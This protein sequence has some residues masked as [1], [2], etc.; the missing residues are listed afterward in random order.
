MCGSLLLHSTE[1][2]VLWT[3]SSAVSDATD[4]KAE[5]QNSTQ[6]RPGPPY[7]QFPACRM[8]RMVIAPTC[9]Y[10]YKYMHIYIYIYIYICI[11]ICIGIYSYLSISFVFVPMLIFVFRFINICVCI[12]KVELVI[13]FRLVLIY[14]C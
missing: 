9:V 10:I 14:V 4:Q 2:V 5:Q 1:E 3:T 8:E 11:C 12:L 7:L 13:E 6:M